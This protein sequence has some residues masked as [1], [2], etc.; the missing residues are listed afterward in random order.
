MGQK[1]IKGLKS[2]L[3]TSWA[4]RHIALKH[5]DQ[6]PVL[7][8]ETFATLKQCFHARRCICGQGT[9]L[10]TA[11]GGVV[12]A[13]ARKRSPGRKLYDAVA[14]VARAYT[15]AGPALWFYIGFGNLASR[16]FT[17]KQMARRPDVEAR[18]PARL[19]SS[20]VLHR[21]NFLQP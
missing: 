17:M 13:V 9:L 5:A 6:P 11:F 21:P 1:C 3:L 2:Q 16:H 12:C 7:Q 20:R 14:L 10:A 4:K 15:A 19:A 8:D 18:L